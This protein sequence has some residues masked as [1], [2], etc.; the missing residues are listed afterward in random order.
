MFNELELGDFSIYTQKEKKEKNIQVYQNMLFPCK[1]QFLTL[2]A[3]E[4]AMYALN[5][6]KHK[7]LIN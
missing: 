5:E 7:K 2:Y 4:I 3:C 6:I 1:L